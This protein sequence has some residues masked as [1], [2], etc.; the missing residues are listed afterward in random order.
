MQKLV[1]EL[2]T[3]IALAE[4]RLKTDNSRLSIDAVV[5]IAFLDATGREINT[6]E[7]I[8]ELDDD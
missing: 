7:Y 2:V 5:R 6:K 8:A 3:V 1:D 4:D